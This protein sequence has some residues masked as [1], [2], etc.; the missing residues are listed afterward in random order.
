[1]LKWKIL[2]GVVAAF[3]ILELVSMPFKTSLDFGD[4]IG[5]I[6]SGLTLIP[7]YGYAY[8]L[9]IGNK[10]I[11]ATIFIVNAIVMAIGLIYALA[12]LIANFNGYAVTVFVAVLV[13]SYLYLLPQY[14]Y[15][16]QSNSI[17]VVD[18]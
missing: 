5:M 9:R 18:S 12:L 2:F 1:M 10:Y 3:F 11:A 15:A 7:L 17:W 16:F 4:L 14:R 6:F 13:C 8:K